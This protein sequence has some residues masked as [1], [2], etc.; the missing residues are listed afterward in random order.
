MCAQ[1]SQSENPVKSTNPRQASFL[2]FLPQISL[3]AET[4][5]WLCEHYHLWTSVLYEELQI[6]QKSGKN[7]PT[8]PGKDRQPRIQV[9]PNQKSF[10]SYDRGE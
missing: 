9:S 3:R 6:P 7:L 8:A 10:S 2:Q 4:E 1:E 5:V